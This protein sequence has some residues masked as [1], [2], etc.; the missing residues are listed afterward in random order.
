MPVRH[1]AQRSKPYPRLLLAIFTLLLGLPFSPPAQ[2]ESAAPVPRTFTVVFF[3]DSLTAGYGLPQEQ[4]YPALV[5]QL[6]NAEGLPW[7]VINAGLSGETSAG[8]LR[9][10]DWVLRR[11]VDAFVL[12]LGANDGLRGIPPTETA[13]NLDAILKRVRGRH[14]NAKVVVVGM[15]MPSN[16]G[17]EFTAAFDRIFPDVAERNDAVLVPFLL[18]GVGG[19]PE[20]NQ[21]DAI[22][23]NAEGQKRLAA[24]VWRYIRPLLT[25][26]PGN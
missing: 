25:N 16:L 21:P 12:A 4:A 20:F 3:G 5:Q 6:I 2:A 13:R 22:H 14:P 7:T 24:T 10:V 9:R 23:P 19:Q 26:A 18:E 17:T 11:P 8:G 1:P 15:R